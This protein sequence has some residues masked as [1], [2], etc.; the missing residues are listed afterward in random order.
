MILMLNIMKFRMWVIR[1]VIIKRI[2]LL[3]DYVLW[4]IV[5]EWVRILFIKRVLMLNILT[6]LFNLVALVLILTV[7]MFGLM[8][9]IVFIKSRIGIKLLFIRDISLLIMLLHWL[10][11]ILYRRVIILYTWIIV[12]DRRWERWWF[13]NLRFE[14]IYLL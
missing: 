12:V 4:I 14:V 2:I 3:L 8:V 10:L 11:V 13:I 5:D 6:F 1:L 7:F 9:L